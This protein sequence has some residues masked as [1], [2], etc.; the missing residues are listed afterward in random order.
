[1]KKNFT[2]I[3]IVMVVIIVG[4]LA[5]F[6]IPGYHNLIERSRDKICELNQKVL[7]KA[8]VTYGL[9]NDILPASLGQL[10][11]RHVE[12]AVA[13]VFKE[14]KGLWQYKLAYFLINFDKRDCAYATS[15]LDGYIDDLK[16]FSC[17]SDKTPPPSGYS[18]GI[19]KSLAGISYAQFKSLPAGTIAIADSDTATF[20]S[21]VS[22]HKIYTI[23]SS[24]INYPIQTTI[25]NTIIGRKEYLTH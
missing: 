20:T 4:I 14:E 7:F 1:M 12:K 3:E 15:W 24:P 13:K 8:V 23:L 6:S 19:N 16:Y 2:L 21:P 9:E 25:E 5:T 17:P 11:N 22:R 18:Y 10:E